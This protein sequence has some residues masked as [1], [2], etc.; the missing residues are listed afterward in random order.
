MPPSAYIAHTHREWF[1]TLSRF[2]ERR[3]ERALHLDEVNFWS[4]RSLKAVKPFDLGEPIFFRLGA[5][6]RCIAGYGFFAA[7]ST[8]DVRLAWQLFGVKNGAESLS[9]LGRL[10]G[11]TTSAS[12]DQP[13]ACMVLRDAVIWPQSRWIPW[14]PERGYAD[15]GVQRGRTERSSDNLTVLLR[16]LAVDGISGPGELTEQF[17]LV[18]TDQRRIALRNQVQREGQGAFRLR[19]LDAYGRQCAITREHTEPVLA[20]AHIQP[21]L[22]PASNHVQNGILLTQEFHTLFDQGL[23]AIEP[24]TSSGGEHRL[25]VSGLLQERW[26]NGRRYRDYDGVALHVPDAPRL[27]PSRGALEWHLEEWFEKAS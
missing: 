13:L 23:V 19:L 21:Y 14:G 10:L 27:Q 5:P 18:A 11:R 26:N 9:D 8:P 16:E 12:L 15:T 24:P 22:G 1:D 2:A 6:T 4:P 3:S 25:K 7:F 17:Q 20:A